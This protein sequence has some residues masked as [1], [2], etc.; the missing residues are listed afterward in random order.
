MIHE[1][2]CNID[3][4]MIPIIHTTSVSIQADGTL[5][6]PISSDLSFSV[7]PNGIQFDIVG[8]NGTD[9][10]VL[11]TGDVHNLSSVDQLRYDYGCSLVQTLRET[12]P[13]LAGNFEEGIYKLFVM[14]KSFRLLLIFSTAHSGVSEIEIYQNMPENETDTISF[15]SFAKHQI[16][17]SL[18]AIFHS[19][20]HLENKD[21][22]LS[23]PCG[24]M[25][26]ET[27]EKISKYAIKSCHNLID[28]IEEEL[29]QIHLDA[30][31]LFLMNT[32]MS[33]RKIQRDLFVKK[34]PINCNITVL[35]SL[36]EQESIPCTNTQQ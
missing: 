33:V 32:S 7:Q 14:Q 2:R 26:A 34:F 31:K 22:L 8:Y 6:Y 5:L 4:F 25:N 29:E 24:C 19:S 17:A 1:N 35:N 15:V 10:I 27:I 18:L 30:T 13:L 20:N 21:T 16:S 11:R 9:S 28:F 36:M 12:V 23:C 3:T